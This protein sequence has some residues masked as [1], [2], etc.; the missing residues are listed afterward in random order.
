MLEQQYLVFME[1]LPLRGSDRF[2][3]MISF[4]LSQVFY[5][6][7]ERFIVPNDENYFF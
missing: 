3:D 2:I 4:M 5:S 1:W 7:T 6:I